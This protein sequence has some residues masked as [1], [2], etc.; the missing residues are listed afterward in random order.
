MYTQRLLCVYLYPPVLSTF[1]PETRSYY[2]VL[3][4]VEICVDQ[5]GIHLPQVCAAN[6]SLSLFRMSRNDCRCVF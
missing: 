6:A 1:S 5:A 3:A 2:V 4:V